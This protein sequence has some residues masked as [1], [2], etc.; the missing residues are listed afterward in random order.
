MVCASSPSIA[1]VSIAGG[2]VPLP[3]AQLMAAWRACQ[4][5]GL[6]SGAF[7]AWLA[8]REMKARRMSIEEGRA[9]AYGFAELARLLGVT[10]KRARALVVRL[11]AAG[12]VHWSNDA[13][14]FPPTPDQD[15]ALTD[16]IG[17]GRGSVAIPRRLLRH[18]AAG[19]KAA[20][21][22]TALGVILRCLSRRRSGFDGRGRIKSSWVAR[23]FGV[24]IRR[25]KAARVELVAIGWIDP[26]PLDQWAA[27]RWGRAYRID[28]A[29]TPPG[30]GMAPPPPA[31]GPR[32]AP[33]CL[34]PD[35]LQELER[36]QDPAPG[37]RTGVEVG[38]S[39]CEGSVRNPDPT[40]SSLSILSPPA[41]KPPAPAPAPR[42]AAAPL[43]PPTLA[44]VRP[45][46]LVDTG[47]ALALL[48]QAVARKLVGPSEADRLKFLALAEHARAIGKVNAPGLFARLLRRGLFSY[49]TQG[50][51]DAAARK[52]KDHLRG[53]PKM[54]PA[55][56][57]RRAEP[58]HPDVGGPS[59]AP[60][61]LGDLM[62]SRLAG[63]AA[64]FGGG[65]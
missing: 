54:I 15:D 14:T 52:L 41:S 35:P 23:A 4:R 29:W 33:P 65:G 51:E 26:E 27:N 42:P 18:L 16:T 9:P 49:A 31:D 28:L 11:V 12:L 17:R 59:A 8:C 37:G 5:P 30:R 24:A 61:S 22:A 57:P 50:D 10:P 48:D 64:R 6:G 1:T 43:P 34:D 60:A 38:V 40:L 46:D 58:R 3:V 20:T 45:E 56:P 25:V 39:K 21:I 55:M 32:A 63:L 13:I 62:A 7:R 2:F 53:V 36:N 19:G 47:R 44:D